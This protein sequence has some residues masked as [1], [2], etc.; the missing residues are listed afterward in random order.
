MLLE[1]KYSF[2]MVSEILSQCADPNSK[3]ELQVNYFD[4]EFYVDIWVILKS[5]LHKLIF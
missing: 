2:G 4:S 1:V 5:R 3:L